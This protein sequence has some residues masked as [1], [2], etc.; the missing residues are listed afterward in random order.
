M[1][2]KTI[3]QDDDYLVHHYSALSE[4][5]K[6]K[7]LAVVD[8]RLFQHM[9]AHKSEFSQR[10]PKAAVDLSFEQKLLEQGVEG[11]RDLL[12]GAKPKKTKLFNFFSK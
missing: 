12:P 10:P 1:G 7:S 4:E 11:I 3:I 9:L 5:M 2:L 6:D 8:E